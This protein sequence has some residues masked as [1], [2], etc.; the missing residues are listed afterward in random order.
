MKINGKITLL[1]IASMAALCL[2][3]CQD[4]QTRDGNPAAPDNGVTSAAQSESSKF[5]FQQPTSQ[6]PSAVE[7]AIELSK[8]YSTLL[9][10]M[11]KLRQE[12]QRLAE[13]NKSLKERVNPCE[14]QLAQTQKELTEANELL[15]DMRI[16]LNNWKANV[17]GFRDEMRQADHAQLEALLKILRVLGGQ[18]DQDQESPQGASTQE[19]SSGADTSEE[20][21]AMDNSNG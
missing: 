17:L 20:S 19:T 13:E 16:E 11:D 8:K 9:E 21:L 7:S 10:E 1:L 15:I 4:A 5:R 14:S 18:V 6:A 2:L 3:G 12:N